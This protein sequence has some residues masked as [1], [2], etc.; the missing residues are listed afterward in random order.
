MNT[1]YRFQRN[2]NIM[3]RSFADVFIARCPTCQQRQIHANRKAP[4]CLL[5]YYSSKQSYGIIA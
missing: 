3:S 4:T 2:P 5:L 1:K